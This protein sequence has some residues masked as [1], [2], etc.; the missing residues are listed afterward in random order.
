MLTGFDPETVLHESAKTSL[1]R[2]R[3]RAD[4]APV[5]LK[6]LNSE[7]PTPAER[8]YLRHEF[9][10]LRRLH[11]PGVVRALELA[12]GKK[13]PVLVLQGQCS[14]TLRREIDL[15]GMSLPRFFAIALPLVRIVAD[16]HRARIVHKDLN[17]SNIILDESG[18]PCIVDFGIASRLPREHAEI[19]PAHIEGLLA[20]VS[21]EQTG[22]MNRALDWRTDIYALG[23]IF[24]EMLTGRPPVANAEPPEMIHAIIARVPPLPHQVRADV[25][26]LLSGIVMRLLAKTVEERYQ[27]CSGLAHDL[28]EVQRRL[29][30]AE[31]LE[32]FE[33]GTHDAIDRFRIPQK[34]YGREEQVAQLLAA[35]ERVARGGVEVL[36]ITGPSG[37]GKS[38]LVREVDR[39]NAVRR[40]YFVDGKFDQFQR[41]V[42][43]GTVARALRALI[44]QLL[45]EPEDRLRAWKQSLGE[46][47]G[48]SGA[49]LTGAIPELELLLG[50]QPPVAPTSS[51]EHR[52]RVELVTLRF[53]QAFANET[54]PL[55]IFLDDLQWADVQSLELLQRVILDQ[56][57]QY[58]LLVSAYRD[59]E[60]D[61]THPLRKMLESMQA[62]TRF[63]SELH[64]GPLRREHVLQ[65]VA[66]TLRREPRDAAP[67]AELIFDKT[68]GNPFFVREF[69]TSL[70]EQGKL[71]SDSNGTWSWDL[72]EIRAQ[73]VTD[74]VAV[75][76]SERMRR[77][78]VETQQVL[79]LAACVGSRFDIQT[80]SVVCEGSAAQTLHLLWPAIEAGLLVPLNASL[81]L[82]RGAQ[83]EEAADGEEAESSVCH[84]A[85]DRVQQA[86]YELV[87]NDKR[88][89]VRLRI[90]RLLLEKL[91]P[92][93]RETRLFEIMQHFAQGLE[94]VEAPAEREQLAE[95][96]LAAGLRAKRA[97][98]Y[99]TAASSFRLGR[100]LLRGDAWESQYSLALKLHSEGAEAARMLLDFA[101]MEALVAVVKTR[102]N[103]V[104]D[105]VSV[106]EVEI[107]YHYSQNR[108]GESL[109]V[110]RELLARLGVVLPAQ[111]SAL[112][113]LP[114]LLSAVRLVRRKKVEALAALPRMTHPVALAAMRIMMRSVPAVFSASPNSFPIIVS[115]MVKLSV[116]HGNSAESSWAYTLLATLIAIVLGKYDEGYELGCFGV[117]LMERLGAREF[118]PRI[119]AS[120]YTTQVQWKRPWRDTLAPL[121][122]A[123][124]IAREIGDDEFACTHAI[125]YACHIIFTGEPLDVVKRRQ[126]EYLA[127]TEQH[128]SEFHSLYIRPLH[129]LALNLRGEGMDPLLL[130]GPVLDEEKTRPQML[131]G[132]HLA[133]LFLVSMCRGILAYLLGNPSD[134][135]THATRARE[136]E[137]TVLGTISTTENIYFQTLALLA[138]WDKATVKQR[139]TLQMNR[140]KIR[141]WANQAPFNFLQKHL[142]V[143]AEW[144]RL[145]GRQMESLQMY[146]QAANAAQTNG[147]VQD[148]AM[149]LERM[150]RY[151]LELGLQRS[152]WG[153]LYDAFRAYRS[154]GAIAKA[155]MLEAELKKASL[156]ITMGLSRD[157]A[158]PMTPDSALDLPTIFT[159]ARAISEEIVLGNLVRKLIRLLIQNAGAERGVLILENDGHLMIEAESTV[160]G[161]APLTSPVPLN[162][163]ERVS[164]SIV[165]Y[166]IRTGQSVV[167]RDASAEGIFVSDPYISRRRPKSVLCAPLLNQQRVIAVVYLENNL[168]S[169]AFTAE[170]LS[171]VHL[172]LSQAALSIHNARLYGNLEVSNRR[173]EEYSH[174]L[175]QKVDE[176]TR[177]LRDKNSELGVML[178]ELRATQQKLVHQEKLA[179]LGALTAA[180]AHELKN[181]LNF[182]NNFAQ[183]SRDLVDEINSTLR[184]SEQEEVIR[185]PLQLL[186]DNI[187]KIHEHGQRANDIINGMLL[188]SSNS[189]STRELVELNAVLAESIGFA[190]HGMRV[191]NPG[192]EVSIHTSYDQAIGELELSA[193]DIR[194]VFI[195]IVNN[196]CYALEEK[197]RVQGPHYTPLLTVETRDAGD[198]AEVHICDNG[199]GIPVE[200]RDKIFNPFFTTK[201]AGKGSGLGLSIS[202][203]I[204]VKGH[205]GELGVESEPGQ[206]TRFIISL[207]KPRGAAT[208]GPRAARG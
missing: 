80:L 143:E 116:R 119:Y 185:E 147:F 26:P 93:E 149:A 164:S 206:L 14:H 40:G 193:V 180:I 83:D 121:E 18:Q 202:H 162:G 144:L 84:F 43:L 182:V 57:T 41:D 118:L 24:Y 53:L 179:S 2:A 146:E 153:H 56:N 3:R 94:L 163:D 90:G 4:G 156:R 115:Q 16:I 161:D 74:N 160:E 159:A 47:I 103:D 54:H 68:Q 9:E 200:V 155:N 19:R 15:G 77:L 20:Y 188:H 189:T 49:L 30:S 170:R 75:L 63:V 8:S 132:K 86:A 104:L 131:A 123:H 48:Q 137:S 34:L 140:R 145:R 25:P 95:L 141:G 110:S 22:R 58:L 172:L 175:E 96:Y 36:M 181:P 55:V 35:F 109:A 66:E 46:A 199:T 39:A 11:I 106:Y 98:A 142:L 99:D 7:Y 65:L 85:H 177:E 107:S 207:P 5:L 88:G 148:A 117:S 87:P 127:F 70:H 17:P 187:V 183:L 176:R 51:E 69:I 171:V 168:T 1:R 73:E 76:L 67:L 139:L 203:D 167:L 31:T 158:T 50:Q 157:S 64:L 71:R 190:Y 124:Q 37:I 91:S 27:S 100:S 197:R 23:A 97:A 82:M 79:Q 134:A 195:N 205:Q 169:D 125:M 150:A 6:S 184:P 165:H 128:R 129:Q 102:A 101:D 166:V 12:E 105:L 194:R 152:G 174:T 81:R 72:G 29:A 198:R 33:L 133:G 196:A 60:F 154:W 78:P 122:Q 32:P 120:F 136:Y 204:I 62:A 208:R 38:A 112:H 113:V 126:A 42:P 13:G 111:P 89:E 59:N 108:L 52:R 92:E 61:A 192:L 45:T 173:L 138:C 201:P 44:R 186:Q 178:G 151:E 21:P 130:A 28:A 191:K 10:L 114:A 135:L